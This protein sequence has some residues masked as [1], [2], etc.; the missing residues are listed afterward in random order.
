MVEARHRYLTA[1][2]EYIDKGLFVVNRRFVHFGYTSDPW[3]RGGG[4]DV[5]FVRRLA[6]I[7]ELWLLLAASVTALGAPRKW[8]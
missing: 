1:A 4:S 7:G 3:A 8:S 6:R 2:L 5:R